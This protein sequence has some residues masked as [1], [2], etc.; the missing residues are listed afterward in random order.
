MNRNSSL[1][2]KWDEDYSDAQVL[3]DDNKKRVQFL[4]LSSRTGVADEAV[5]AG[6]ESVEAEKEIGLVLAIKEFVND[7]FK[8]TL[9]EPIPLRLEGCDRQFV[10][11]HE[12]SRVC[13][14]GGDITS[15]VRDFEDT[16]ISVFLA[17]N[18]PTDVLSSGAKKYAEYLYRLVEHIEKI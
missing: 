14:Y 1:A 13:G 3:P 11:V 2:Y 6:W 9:R 5:G 4:P 7:E 18:E 12:A 17:Y 16:F 8:I 10:A 15:A